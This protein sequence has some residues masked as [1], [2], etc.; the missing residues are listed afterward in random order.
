MIHRVLDLETVIAREI[1]V[2]RKDIVA[3]DV[4]ASLDEVLRAMIHEKHSRL[5]GV[6]REA[7]KDRRHSA[8]QGPAAGLGG[9]AHRHPH[10]PPEPR[11]SHRAP[12]AAAAGGARNQAAFA[13]SRGV[14][15]R[16]LP[17][18]DGGGRVRHD[19]RHADGGGRSRT[20]RGP[21]RGRARREGCSRARRSGRD[22]AGWR[23]PHSRP[24]ERVRHRDP[25]DGGFETLAGFLLAQLG[26]IPQAGRSRGFRRAASSRCSRW[27]ATASRAFVWRR[28]CRRT[29]PRRVRIGRTMR[30]MAPQC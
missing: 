13:A 22:R 3:I 27:I 10:R 17:H 2:P 25:S 23:D 16:P 12:A 18:G 14:P 30:T 6:G 4:N 19:H 20:T 1:M 28:S 5:P 21:H 15:R 29:R 9:A 7:G 26:E 8:L 24:G 11:V